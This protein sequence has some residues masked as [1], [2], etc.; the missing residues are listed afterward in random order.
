MIRS[1]E[2]GRTLIHDSENYVYSWSEKLNSYP[3]KAMLKKIHDNPEDIDEIRSYETYEVG[4]GG[5][6]ISTICL[7]PFNKGTIMRVRRVYY[8]QKTQPMIAYS[9]GDFAHLL[10]QKIVD[11]L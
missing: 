10:N 9:R 8:G 2:K 3:D 11:S 6:V 1:R 4:E 5:I 7:R